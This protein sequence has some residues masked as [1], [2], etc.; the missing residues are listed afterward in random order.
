M[1]SF[2]GIPFN[3]L[4]KRLVAVLGG[5]PIES[6]VNNAPYNSSKRTIKK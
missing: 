5:A 4:L 6:Y 1:T 2:F 3:Q